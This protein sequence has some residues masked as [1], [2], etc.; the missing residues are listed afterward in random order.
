MNKVTSGPRGSNKLSNMC[1]YVRGTTQ[2]VKYMDTQT[3]WVA[4]GACCWQL[5]VIARFR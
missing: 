5:S 3:L 2:N 4:P 1:V